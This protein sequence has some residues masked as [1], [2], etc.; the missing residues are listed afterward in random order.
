MLKALPDE[1]KLGE[2]SASFLCKILLKVFN[3][4]IIYHFAF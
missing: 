4:K 3:V 1:K 2:I